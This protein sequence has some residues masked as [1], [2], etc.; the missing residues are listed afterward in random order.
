ME[1]S[2]RR[3]AMTTQKTDL[4]SKRTSKSPDLLTETT[5]QGKI[6]LTEQELDQASGGTKSVGS[7][8]KAEFLKI[9]L[10]DII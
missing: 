8:E 5:A 2:H 3:E 7:S 4:D 1:L 9:K 6:E 10:T